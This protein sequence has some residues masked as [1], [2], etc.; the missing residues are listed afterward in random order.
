MSRTGRRP[1]RAILT[2]QRGFTMTEM[3]MVTTVLAVILGGVILVQQQGQQAYLFG[4]HRIE[5]QQNGRAALEL[6]SRELRS[7][8]SVTA[9]AGTTDLTFL[10]STG[11]TIRYRLTGG[12]L[13]RTIGGASTPLIGG[14]QSLAMTC[15]SA[16]DG[17]TNTG[18]TTTVPGAVKLVRLQIV[19]GTEDVAGPGTPGDQRFALESLVRLRNVP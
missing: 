19:T 3:L 7:A 12:T 4:S 6:M 16:W 14:V 15:Y 1:W 17:S 18:T 8:Q 11:T 10:D 9:L 2:D 13:S 5:V